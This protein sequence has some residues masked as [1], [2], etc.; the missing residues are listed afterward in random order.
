MST[1]TAL[2]LAYVISFIINLVPAFMPPTFTVL[3][4]FLIQ[5]HPPLLLLTIGGAAASTI[6]RLGLALLTQRFG[7]HLLSARHRKNLGQLGAWLE[8]KPHFILFLATLV[9]AGITPFPSNQLFIAAGLTGIRLTP[10]LAGF[11]VGRAIN[12]TALNLLTVQAVSGL[13][14]IFVGHLTNIGAIIFEIL[15]LISI[16][17]FAQIDWPRLLHISPTQSQQPGDPSHTGRDRAA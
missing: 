11:F 4:F 2:A 13:K 15:V 7:R 12:Y 6:G 14:G 3:A 8:A 1:I 9:F 16:I 5:Y 17:A 10:I